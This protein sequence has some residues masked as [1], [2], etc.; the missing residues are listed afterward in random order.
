MTGKVGQLCDPCLDEWMSWLDYK[1]PWRPRL[2]SI[3]NIKHDQSLPFERWKE[4]ILS[5]QNVIVGI[6]LTR[7]VG[8]LELFSAG[9]R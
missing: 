6:C 9:S 4:T 3:G 2:I 5:Q 8:Q 1:Q 7:H